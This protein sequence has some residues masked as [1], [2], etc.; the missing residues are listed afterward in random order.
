MHIA[1]STTQIPPATSTPQEIIAIVDLSQERALE[2][3]ALMNDI[4]LRATNSSTTFRMSSFERDALIVPA[5]ALKELPAANDFL[6]LPEDYSVTAI[7]PIKGI[8]ANVMPLYTNWSATD[9]NDRFILTTVDLTSQLLKL[10]ARGQSLTPGSTN[11]TLNTLSSTNA[12]IIA[13]PQWLH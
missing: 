5:Y 1:L 9:E 8:H 4:T 12:I 10:V 11:A 7:T 3:L 6:I 13:E 2:L